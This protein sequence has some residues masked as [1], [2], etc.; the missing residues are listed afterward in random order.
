MSFS[1]LY[2]EGDLEQLKF[3]RNLSVLDLSYNRIEDPLVIDIL[4]EMDILKGME[5]IQ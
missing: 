3:C 2:F 1:S 5:T 4:A